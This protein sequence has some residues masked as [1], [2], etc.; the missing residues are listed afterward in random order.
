MLSRLS[1][2]TK[3]AMLLGLAML[4]VIAAI[5]VGAS[6]LHGTMMADRA[7]KLRAIV[8][9]A[10]G[11]ADNLEHEVAAQHITR[12]QATARLREAIH[13]MRFDDG[14]GYVVATRADSFVIIAH[15]TN[16]KREGTKSD[17]SDGQGHQLGDLEAAAT[18]ATGEGVVSYV[19]PKP[20]QTNPIGKMSY[21][22]RYAPLNAY[23]L[24]GAYT[25]DIDAAF[26]AVLFRLI[27]IGALVM[28]GLIAATWV[29]NRDVTRA[30][31]RLRGAMERLATGDLTVTV[32]DTERRDEFGFMAR[33]LSVFKD[34]A[35]RMASMEI[36]QKAA[37]VRAGEE[38]RAALMTLAD[39]FDQQV[40]SVVEVVA[41]A[42]TDMGAAARK[43]TGTAEAAAKQ[44]GSALTEAEQATQNVQGVAAAVEQMTATGS[45]ISRQVSRAAT[46]ARDA[47]AEGRRTNDSVASLAAAAQKVGDVVQLIQDIAAQTNLLALNATIE[48]ARAG[49]AGKGFAVVAGEVKSLATQTA[50]ATEDI[51]AQIA[52]I[53]SETASAL[54]AIGGISETVHGVEQIAATIASAVEEQGAAMREVSSNVQQAAERTR[55]VAQDLTQVTGGL[56]ANGD[57]ATEMRG[58][59]ERLEEQ[60][61][62]LRREVGDFLVS[63]RAA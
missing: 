21:V 29:I 16:P 2:R 19:F 55:R 56:G 24:A 6:A 61:K 41:T 50:R 11:I 39:R 4:A 14:V 63:I 49:D 43:V 46:I 5:A 36:E 32:P 38:K 13:G 22:V 3:L 30:S 42:G 40:G 58:S 62:V 7:D 15:G 10:V 20:G 1:L 26:Q 34:N 44:A 12:E 31:Q 28:V 27:G 60:A 48:A 53:Q 51:R 57:A 52:A 25:D 33:A 9:T 8:R 59:A 45:E 18:R 37:T 35:A 47:A 54:Q 17:A 23:F